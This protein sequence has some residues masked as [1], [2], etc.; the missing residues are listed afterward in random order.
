MTDAVPALPFEQ[1]LGLVAAE[2][3]LGTI[4]VTALASAAALH[5]WLERRGRAR[6][7]QVPVGSA[8]IVDGPY[9][10]GGVVMAHRTRAPALV[11]ASA[12]AS[13]LF[14]HG[15]APLLLLALMRFPFDG[16]SIPLG[17]GLVLVAVH[18]C[19]GWLL[20]LRSRH[21]DVAVRTAAKASLVANVGLVALAAA[22]LVTV[23]LGRR[24]GI[25]HACSS[26]VTFVAFVFA[27]VSVLQALLA[28]AAV[29]V[30]PGR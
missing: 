12:F 9:R 15:S 3:H 1:S 18:W 14:A 13:F 16:V 22:H 17:A 28:L 24:E 27:G 19:C 21:A 29:P 8:E 5:V 10:S 26:S 25:A 23:E 30:A 2:L 6:W 20:L 11:R 7:A 4:A